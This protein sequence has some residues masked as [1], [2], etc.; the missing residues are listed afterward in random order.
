MEAT[1]VPL[2]PV[3]AW[4]VQ[5]GDVLW[6]DGRQIVVLAEPRGALYYRAGGAGPGLAIDC[7]APSA[8]PG[9]TATWTLFRTGSD[10]L[11]RVRQAVTG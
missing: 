1:P 8:H 6:H 2:E 9:G 4:Q 3:A 11:H 5:A 7:R 10:L